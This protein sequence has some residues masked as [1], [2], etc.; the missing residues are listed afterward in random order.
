MIEDKSLHHRISLFL[1]YLFLTFL[2][3]TCVFPLI[4]VAAIS[5]S[6]SSAVTA[7]KV[8]FWP[9]GFNTSNY[10]LVIYFCGLINALVISI[11]RVVV[12]ATI[13]IFI[14]VITAYPLS[15]E[16][17]EMK[18]RNAF[19]WFMVIPMLFS[20]GL[21]PFYLAV[22]NL[23]MMDKFL[24]L[25][26]PCA[27]QI[28]N[29]ILMMNFFRNLPKELYEASTID[30][31]GHF[32]ILLKIF[33]PVSKA[34][35]ATIALFS[36]VFHWNSWFDGYI[37]IND[38]RKMPLQSVLQ[39]MLSQSQQLL[40]SISSGGLLTFDE[41]RLLSDRALMAALIIFNTVPVL[42]FYPFLQKYF[43]KGIVLG[44]VKG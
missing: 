27:V 17:K 30:G 35:I 36:I 39:I 6:Q 21:I 12:G 3:F 32:T 5:F 11:K 38:V 1:I 13:N 43:V 22:R 41:L 40:N 18:G 26:I 8:T 28:Y 15:R 34:S 23:G 2:A 9:I 44:S 10:K 19:M 7:N 37:F 31:A 4:N 42:L 16:S 24:A 25:V 14:T 33:I 29:T 20:G